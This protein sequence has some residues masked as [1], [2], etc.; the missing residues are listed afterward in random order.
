MKAIPCKLRLHG[1]YTEIPG[2]TL[3]SISAAK[4]WVNECWPRPYTI[5]K[6]GKE[7]KK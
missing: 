6:I 1:A 2:G 7:I 5:E 3:P 4:K